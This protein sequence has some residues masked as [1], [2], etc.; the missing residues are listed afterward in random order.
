[1]SLRPHWDIANLP[2]YILRGAQ[3]SSGTFG[4]KLATMLARGAYKSYPRVVGETGG[5]NWHL[6]HQ[7]ADVKNTVLQSVRSPFKYQGQFIPSSF[8]SLMLGAQNVDRPKML[9]TF[10]CLCGFVSVAPVQADAFGGDC[11]NQ[12]WSLRQVGKRHGSSNVSTANLHSRRSL[13][14]LRTRSKRA[15]RF[16]IVETLKFQ[17]DTLSSQLL[18]KRRTPGR[19][20]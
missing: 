20:R 6:V 13:A 10:K 14:I 1:M 15:G 2:G 3:R 12:S 18:F 7:S 4:R 9:S 16:C 5:K 17:L 11:E 8:P 19:S